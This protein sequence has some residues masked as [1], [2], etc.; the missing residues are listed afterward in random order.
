MKKNNTSIIIFIAFLF[1]IG[2]FNLIQNGKTIINY[3]E[4][5]EID[6]ISIRD[7]SFF[8]GIEEEFSDNFIF[9]VSPS[10]VDI[11]EELGKNGNLGGFLSDI[12]IF[13]K[14]I[15]YIIKYKTPF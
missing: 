1:L 6:I 9:K 3:I 2:F 14:I 7:G 8:V 11:E 4:Y 12:I 5:E 13:F 15:I 10:V